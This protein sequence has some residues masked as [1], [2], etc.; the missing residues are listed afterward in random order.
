[1]STGAIELGL[2]VLVKLNKIE[3]T[4]ISSRRVATAPKLIIWSVAADSLDRS[5]THAV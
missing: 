5:A 2:P 3:A 1:M 4:G